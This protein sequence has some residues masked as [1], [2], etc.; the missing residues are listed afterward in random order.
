M[1]AHL[2]KIGFF[3]SIK[4]REL[5]KGAPNWARLHWNFT[6]IIERQ[7]TPEIK[8]KFIDPE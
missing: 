2:T 4:F 6:L 3:R 8:V 5:H 1:T 7:E